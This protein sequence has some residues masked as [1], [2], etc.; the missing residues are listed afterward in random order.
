MSICMLAAGLKGRVRCP[1]QRESSKHRVREIPYP[2][3]T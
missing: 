3:D 2:A 1:V